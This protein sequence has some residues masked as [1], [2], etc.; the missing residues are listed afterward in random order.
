[1]SEPLAIVTGASGFVGSHIVD[2]LLRR[3][4]RVRC[5]LRPESSTRWLDGKS[6]EITRLDFEDAERL[7]SAVLDA[8]W[9]VHAAGLTHA[10]SAKEFHAANV[11]GTERMLRAAMTLGDGLRRFVLIS[12]QAAAGPALGDTPVRESDRPDPVS[13]Y[14]RSKLRSEELTMLLKDRIPVVAIRPPAVYGPRDQAILKLFLA[15]KRHILPVLREDGRFSLIYVDDLA[16]A[17]HLALTH[18]RAT[19]QVFF[20]GEP[21]VTDYREIGGCVKR[22]LGSWTVTIRPPGPLLHAGAI[23]GEMWG[24]LRN[25]PPF[26][27]RE[28][29]DE[30]TAGDWTF[31]SAKIRSELGWVPEIS[32]EEGIGRTAGWYREAGWL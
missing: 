15:V 27:S 31:T 8:T 7:A 30:I 12:S 9:I 16:R 24:F 5:L 28:K 18:P 22:A 20:V 6:I 3:G 25:R 17:V 4:V 1:M 32:L 13:P 14:G 10:T 19:G 2:E 26:L 21:D 29:L 23:A 11:G